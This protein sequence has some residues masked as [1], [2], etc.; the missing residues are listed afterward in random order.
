MIIEIDVKKSSM[1]ELNVLRSPN[2]EEYTSIKFFKDRGFPLDRLN[3]DPNRFKGRHQSLISI[4]TAYSSI[5][6]DVKSRAPEIAPVILEPNEKLRLHIFVD[7]SVVEVFVNEKQALAVRVYPGRDDSKGISIR[8]QGS[9]A[10]IENLY[11]WQM[12]SIYN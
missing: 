2:K 5:L 6:P 3:P 12:K 8:A 7:K 10:S 4:E 11:F 9:D 1:V